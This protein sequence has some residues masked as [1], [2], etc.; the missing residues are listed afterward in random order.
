[1]ADMYLHIGYG[2]GNTAY[3]NL[4]HEWSD[5]GFAAAVATV[6][7]GTLKELIVHTFTNT[8]G[9]DRTIREVG[10]GTY[11]APTEY[12]RVVLDIDDMRN[13]CIVPAGASVTITY[14]WWHLEPSTRF[15]TCELNTASLTNSALIHFNGVPLPDAFITNI[16]KTGEAYTWDIQCHTQNKA[17]IEALMAY[18]SPISTD[19]SILGKQYVISPARAGTLNIMNMSTG[20]HDQHDNCYIE[21]PISA[22]PVI[23]GVATEEYFFTVTVVQSAYD[24]V[25]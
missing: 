11:Y 14:W 17:D 15:V 21:G 13:N 7:Y 16:Q 9:E 3:S 10:C 4:E 20:T 22:D 5:G 25:L 19:Y 8:S 6:D 18:A 12:G 1:M 24:E 23:T 2:S